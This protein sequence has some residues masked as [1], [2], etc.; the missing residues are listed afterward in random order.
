MKKVFKYELKHDG[1]TKLPRS[2]EVVHAD[3]Q[4]GVPYIWAE[5]YADEE[6]MCKRIGYVICGTGQP[7]PA[8]ACHVKTI[9]D[10]PYVWHVYR[11]ISK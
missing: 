5:V 3:M 8:M 7:L 4:N 1:V 10:G 2:H 11:I 6:V 9:M